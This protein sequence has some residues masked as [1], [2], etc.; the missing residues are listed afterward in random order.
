MS[1]SIS[2]KSVLRAVE[3]ANGLCVTRTSNFKKSLKWCDVKVLTGEQETEVYP[4]LQALPIKLS[5]ILDN[6]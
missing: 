2:L 4:L 3:P 6:L 5:F 1:L